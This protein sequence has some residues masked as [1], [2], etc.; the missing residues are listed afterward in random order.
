VLFTD[1]AGFTPIAERMA[2]PAALVE[3]LQGYLDTMSRIVGAHGGVINKYIGD[4][5]MA[6]Y[7]LP[8]G[9]STH[10]EIARDARAAVETALAMRERLRALN[11]ER[12]AAAGGQG[13]P[14]I[15]TRVGIYTGE[16]IAGTVGAPDR[17]E[18]TV[19]GDS[20]NVASRLESFD[21]DVL[22]PTDDDPCRILVGQTTLDHLPGQF[23]TEWVGNLSVK[24][25]ETP[26][27]VHRVI[28]RAAAAS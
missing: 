23:Q 12:A 3:W 25:R 6:I 19:I 21:K 4:A 5:I 16:M 28:A 17:L 9:R 27:A 1:I 2:S 24:G 11:T 8:I 18:Y 20:V 13:G 26:V 7:G 22:A 15:R 10:E 14:P